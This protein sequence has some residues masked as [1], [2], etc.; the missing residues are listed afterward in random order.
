M[1]CMLW[2]FWSIN[3]TVNIDRLR[4]RSRVPIMFVNYAPIRIV[5]ALHYRDEIKTLIHV[6]LHLPLF[7]DWPSTCMANA[8]FS[9]PFYNINV[10]WLY[11]LKVVFH[12]EIIQSSTHPNHSCGRYNSNTFQNKNVGQKIFCCIFLMKWNAK[13]VNFRDKMKQIPEWNWQL[14]C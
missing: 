2:D 9:Q 6:L 7:H 5:G 8:I 14:W 12:M 1:K 3:P 4:V 10:Q 11:L 13:T